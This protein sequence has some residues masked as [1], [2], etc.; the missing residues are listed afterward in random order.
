MKDKSNENLIEGFAIADR[1]MAIER[2]DYKA[3]LMRRL[4]E[5][6][7]ERDKFKRGVEN[8]Q[9]DHA[10][11]TSDYLLLK[12]ILATRDAVIRELCEALENLR[13]RL[14][15]LNCYCDYKTD[16]T[17]TRARALLKG[18]GEPKRGVLRFKLINIYWVLVGVDDEPIKSKYITHSDWMFARKSKSLCQEFATAL[19]LEAEFVEED[20]DGNSAKENTES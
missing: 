17:L 8:L 7:A 9:R 13:E 19:G 1:N 15:G 14:I 16:N 12:T 3:E 2:G 20:G 4:A 6:E 11:L 18:Q 10:T 5:R